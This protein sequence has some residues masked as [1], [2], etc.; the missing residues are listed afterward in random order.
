M[1]KQIADYCSIVGLAIGIFGLF[2]TFKALRAAM[3]AREAAKLAA[4]TVRN[5][6][7][8]SEFREASHRAKELLNHVQ[9]RQSDLAMVRATDLFFVV[10]QAL[11]HWRPKLD[12]PSFENLSLISDQLQAISRSLSATGIPEDPRAF[13]TLTD[14]CHKV[15]SAMSEEAGKFQSEVE[16]ANDE[17]PRIR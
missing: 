7:A 2:L 13:R 11:G 6:D 14:R 8:A 5:Q 4:A 12:A 1:W 15:L 3:G 16:K 17:Q 9:N 10:Q